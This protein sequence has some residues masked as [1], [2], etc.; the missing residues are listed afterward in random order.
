MTLA[1]THSIG[2]M[3]LKEATSCSQ[4]GTQ[5]SGKDTIPPTKLSTQN[6]PCLQERQ[7]TD[8]HS[9]GIELGDSL[10]E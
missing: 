7:E 1:M 2:D 9:Q 8:T 4:A 6:L 10:E 3:E 5:W